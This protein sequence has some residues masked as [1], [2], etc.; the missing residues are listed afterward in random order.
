MDIKIILM[1][2]ILSRFVGKLYYYCFN[3]ISITKP[4]LIYV[5]HHNKSNEIG[6]IW[7]CLWSQVKHFIVGAMLCPHGRMG[8][9]N[10][11]DVKAAWLL[12]RD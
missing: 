1:I 10:V 11:R 3:Y 8:K 2:C 12:K 6:F 4:V 7:S 9:E 5:G